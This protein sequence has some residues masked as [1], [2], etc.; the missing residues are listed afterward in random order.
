[1]AKD[2]ILFNKDELTYKHK[3]YRLMDLLISK[4]GEFL[5]EAYLLL[6]I[7]YI[8]I[9]S[10]FFSEQIGVFT[11]SNGKSDQVLNYIEKILFLAYNY[12]SFIYSRIN[13]NCSFFIIYIINVKNIL[14]FI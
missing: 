12:P 1:M 3:F 14:L 6:A 2:I 8:Q 13:N 7:F 4:Q 10:S 11:S 9:L 5:G